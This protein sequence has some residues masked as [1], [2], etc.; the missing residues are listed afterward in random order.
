MDEFDT[1]MNL[2]VGDVATEAR[3]SY[4]LS[5]GDEVD[6]FKI[7]GHIG[8]G[9][10]SE[11]YSAVNPDFGTECALKILRE[12]DSSG[13]ERFTHEAQLLVGIR[14]NNI[15]RVFRAGQWKGRAWIA[16][17]RLR[18][19]PENPTPDLVREWLLKICSA[20]TALSNAGIVHRDIKTG[21]IL[22]DPV[23]REPVLADFGIAAKTGTKSSSGTRGWGA[24][25]Q[26][27]GK[28]PL[29]SSADVFALGKFAQSLLPPEV[30]A[31][32]PWR[33]ILQQTLA[34]ERFLRLHSA[35]QLAELINREFPVARA[36]GG[37]AKLGVGLIAALVALSVVGVLLLVHRGG[38]TPPPRT[39]N[40]SWGGAVSAAQSDGTSLRSEDV[41]SPQIIDTQP[42]ALKHSEVTSRGVEVRLDWCAEA[43]VCRQKTLTLYVSKDGDS[44]VTV[45]IPKGHKLIVSEAIEFVVYDDAIVNAA[46]NQ[47]WAKVRALQK[48]FKLKKITLKVVGG[49]E[50][51]APKLKFSLA[52]V[53][54]G[55]VIIRPEMKIAKLPNGIAPNYRMRLQLVCCCKKVVSLHLTVGT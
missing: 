52:G 7:T 12:G 25:E 49:G 18:A 28:T 5:V 42:L 10:T 20:V 39:G 46:M 45:E 41:S 14:H 47:D 27:D 44:E 53:E 19:L 51:D 4:S 21:N 26:F 33:R 15:V 37:R 55:Q 34:Q 30:A 40:D 6:G 17:E 50:L 22:W 31:A 3:R 54:D 1:L 24:P 2:V 29:D 38:E 35:A 13:V 32:D 11:V 23:R 36:T 9:A 8:F 16:M 48:S 43:K